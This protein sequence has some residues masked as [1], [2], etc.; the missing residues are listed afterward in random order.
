MNIQFDISQEFLDS[1]S[2]GEA[3]GLPKAVA[4][5]IRASLDISLPSFGL[6]ILDLFDIFHT[7]ILI[8][9]LHSEIRSFPL[10]KSLKIR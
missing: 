1:R 9:I 7:R 5:W 10:L 2:A 3:R 6:V 4:G 8:F